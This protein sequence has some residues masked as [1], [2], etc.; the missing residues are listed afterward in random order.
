MMADLATPA[1]PVAVLPGY[2]R[3]ATSRTGEQYGPSRPAGV[4][5]FFGGAEGENIR[6]AWGQKLRYPADPQLDKFV[7]LAGI[8]CL[9]GL[10]GTPA[11]GRERP[12][13]L[14]HAVLGEVLGGPPRGRSGAPVASSPRVERGSGSPRK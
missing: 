4:E 3:V 2:R 9:V 8:L 5:G 12:R 13:H 1:P 6:Y 7:R 11:V 10:V 14:R